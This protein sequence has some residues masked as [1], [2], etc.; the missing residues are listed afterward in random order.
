VPLALADAPPAASCD[1]LMAPAVP[2]PPWHGLTGLNLAALREVQRIACGRTPRG[3]SIFGRLGASSLCSSSSRRTRAR[4]RAAVSLLTFQDKSGQ[5]CILLLR[6]TR[7]GRHAGQLCFPGGYCAAGESDAETAARELREE[8]GLSADRDEGQVKWLSPA[9][10]AF[11]TAHTDV[12]VMAYAG[13]FDLMSAVYSSD[14]C[15]GG[16]SSIDTTLGLAV[17]L[18]EVDRAIALP[19][20]MLC[21]GRAVEL[22]GRH[23]PS[24]KSVDGNGAGGGGSLA[25]ASDWSQFVYTGPIFRLR[26]K[27][28][29]TA[30]DNGVTEPMVWGLTARILAGKAR[31]HVIL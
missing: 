18:R 19:L 27:A 16:A 29:A 17:D 12:D 15:C 11:R 31:P 28:S 23:E 10:G 26:G 13:S 8:C 7:G 20:E 14:V 25:A 4:A 2:P 22:S 24:D 3:A 21:D 30:A 6:K 1:I 5:P 9:L